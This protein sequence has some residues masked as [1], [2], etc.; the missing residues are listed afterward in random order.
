MPLYMDLHIGQGLTAEDVAKAHQLDLEIQDEFKCNCLTYWFDQERNNVFCLIEAPSKEAAVALHNAAHEQLP[1]EIIEVD[2]RIVKAFLGRIMDPQVVDYMIDSKIK[3]YNDPAFR[4]IFMVSVVNKPIVLH[5]LGREKAEELLKQNKNKI[6]EII[7]N[8]GG[9]T[10]DSVS[11]KLIGT[12]ESPKNTYQCAMDIQNELAAFSKDLN[13]KMAIHAGNP[14]DGDTELFGSTLKC[15]EFICS[16]FKY[17][18]LV[19]SNTVYN[20]IQ[21]E[22]LMIDKTKV[23]LLSKQEE[24]FIKKLIKVLFTHWVNSDFDV[25]YLGKELLLSNSQLYRKCKNILNK[26]PNQLLRDFRLNQAL[27]ILESSH[28]TISEIAFDSGFNNP[29]YFTKCFQK[30]FGMKPL[31]FK[32]LASLK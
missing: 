21:A 26:S 6:L 15:L 30:N 1:D 5:K 22:D 9:V 8:H 20:L 17:G 28:K 13:L 14:V 3:V 4:V 27:F 32:N 18:S 10:A 24:E 2:K 7:K 16:G 11:N 25:E 29:S 12:F 19:I 31:E 23:N